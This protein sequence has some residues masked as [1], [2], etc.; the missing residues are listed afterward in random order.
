M[1]IEQI[2]P[3]LVVEGADEAIRYYGEVFG[4]VVRERHG[5]AGRVVFAELELAGGVVFQ[6]K[7][8]DAVDS[9]P[10]VG[11]GVLLSVVV[12]DPDGLAGRMVEGGGVVVFGVADQEYGIRQGRVRDPFG[13][14]WIV[15][16]PL[17]GA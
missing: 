8:A 5:G 14:E 4:A 15:G 12:D 1:K 13:H 3:K 7:D 10:G 11:A 2:T 17:G 16:G 9:A 6:V